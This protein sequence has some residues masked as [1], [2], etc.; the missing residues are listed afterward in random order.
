MDDLAALEAMAANARSCSTTLSP[1]HE[2]NDAEETS[3][4]ECTISRW[5][6]LF[7]LSTSEARSAIAEWRGDLSR[8]E[9]SNQLWDMVKEEREN[10]GWDK[11]A[12]GFWLSR[13]GGMGK[14]DGDLDKPEDAT[15]ASEEKGRYIIKLDHEL[16]AERIK[17][18][19]KLENIPEIKTGW[20]DGDDDERTAEEAQFCIISASTRSIILSTPSLRNK[21]LTIIKLVEPAPKELSSHSRYP[22]LGVETT[23][24]QFRLEA[25]EAPNPQQNEYPIPYFFYGT[26]ADSEI[27]SRLL[28]VDIQTLVLRKAYVRGGKLSMWGK[29]NALLDGNDIVEGMAFMVNGMKEENRLR[30]YETSSYEVVRCCID[31]EDKE[32]KREVMGCTFRFIGDAD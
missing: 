17:E 15:A 21:S 18:L 28:Q 26:L 5:K 4:N 8:I 1:C 30:T 31:V 6:V 13:A 16:S 10:D 7:S 29:Y 14:L 24:P 19:S 3:I 11:E 12:Y 9:V 23:L 25:G 27:L 20:N 22:T 2:N 32:Q